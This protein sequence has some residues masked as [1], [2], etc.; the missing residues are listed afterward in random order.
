MKKMLVL[1]LAS[2]FAAHAMALSLFDNSNLP[3]LTASAST[4]SNGNVMMGGAVFLAGG[5]VAHTL[6]GMTVY[7]VFRATA[8][9]FDLE[10]AVSFWNTPDVG[11]TSASPL[12]TDNLFKNRIGATRVFTLGAP[13]SVTANTFQPF[14]LTLPNIATTGD[15]LGVQIRY[16]VKTTAAGAF[17]TSTNV[18]N[19]IR[20][21]ASTSGGAYV[22]PA[23]GSNIFSDPGGWMRSSTGLTNPD[24]SMQVTNERIFVDAGQLPLTGDQSLAF[25][26]QGVPE[27]SSVVAM[28]LGGLAIM[29]RRRRK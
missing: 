28:A 11:L 29:S 16:R 20:L 21:G 18:T 4:A 19:G 3:V 9:Y 22:A 24:N 26:L 8:N 7:P 5:N 27:P 2:G 17:A 14:N 15:F 10:I 25:T 6:T 1:A 12:A 13:I 23:V